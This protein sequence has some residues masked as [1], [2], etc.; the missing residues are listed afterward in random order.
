[1]R[2]CPLFRAVKVKKR[3]K[4]DGKLGCYKNIP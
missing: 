3:K 2:N 1:M 4:E